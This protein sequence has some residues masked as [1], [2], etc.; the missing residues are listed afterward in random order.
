MLDTSDTKSLNELLQN[1]NPEALTE[2]LRKASELAKNTPPTDEYLEK[3][4]QKITPG[5][6]KSIEE[7]GK[8]ESAELNSIEDPTKDLEMIGSGMEPPVEKLIS[9]TPS[10]I[11][12]NKQIVKSKEE[13]H[14]KKMEKL[15]S[16]EILDSSVE[17]DNLLLNVASTLKPETLRSEATVIPESEESKEDEDLLEKGSGKAAEIRKVK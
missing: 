10:A 15:T 14:K 4:R 17:K 1:D 11:S 5:L 2:T 9:L 6:D 16:A 3:L 8:M 7:L 13:G 12:S